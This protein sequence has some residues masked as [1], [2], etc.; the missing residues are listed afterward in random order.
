MIYFL[1]S[2][3]AFLVAL[4]IH[5][6]AHAW[7]ANKLGDPNPKISGRLTLNPLA[8]IDPIGTIALPLFLFLS[9]LPVFGWAKPVQVD[10][11]NFRNP[12][13]DLGLV[14]LAGP[15][16]NIILAAIFSFISRI[17]GFSIGLAS[18]VANILFFS[19]IISNLYIAIFNLIPIHP[20]DGGKILVGFLP[21]HL[22]Y[23]IDGFLSQ[24]GQILLLFLIFPFFGRSLIF[25]IISPVV[26]FFFSIFLPGPSFF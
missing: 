19:L 10:S 5:E 16:A 13:R 22:S 9:G 23:K 14:S 18:P 25:T 24:Y 3:I 7:V 17:P 26:N 4:T 11:Y 21:P 2:I 1:A 8:H 12:R 6:F 20:L 15:G